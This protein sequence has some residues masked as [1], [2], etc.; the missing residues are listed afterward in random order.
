MLLEVNQIKKKSQNT[1]IKDLVIL[2]LALLEIT[3]IP[4]R[5]LYSY[6]DLINLHTSE[7]YFRCII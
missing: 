5:V 1:V 4:Y 6:R 2:S 7:K 3:E